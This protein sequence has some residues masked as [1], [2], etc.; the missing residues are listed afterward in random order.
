MLAHQILGGEV[1]W[2]QWPVYV[3]A[4]LFA[5]FLAS[6]LHGC[7]ANAQFVS[8]KLVKEEEVRV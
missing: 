8:Q 2:R 3:G 6:L 1:A 7:V 4:E 5:G